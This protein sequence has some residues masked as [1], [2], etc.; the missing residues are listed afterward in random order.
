MRVY[1]FNPGPATL[2]TAVLEK[3]QRQF[4]DYHGK[5]LSVME[6]SHRSPE[7]D[8]IHN[9]AINNIRKIMSIPDNYH[10][11]FLQGGASTQFFHIPYN[12]LSK[13]TEADYI[14]TGSWSKKAI[15]EAKLFGKVNVAASSEDVDF[16]R[17]PEQSEMNFSENAEYVH[18]TSNNTIYG[19]QFHTYPDT[20]NIPL[21]ADMSSDIMS[22]RIDVSEFQLI[23]AGAQKNMGPAGVTLVILSDEMANKAKPDLPTMVNYK[24][25]IE[26]N[27]L[28]NTP[29]T[30]GI[31]MIKLVTDWII[32]IGGI[33]KVEEINNAKAEMLYNAID[34]NPDFF[35]GTT[36]KSSRSKMN[37][38]MRLPSED[39]EKEFIEGASKEGMIGLK[40]HRSV[41]G[42]RASLYNALP[43]DGVKKL[44]DFMEDFA[45]KHA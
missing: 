10:V 15:K 11:L 43:L 3:A 41:G 42:I 25:H 32:E 16:T 5:G 23:Y 1:N 13:E 21:I 12:F 39:L 40:G 31:Y 7:Y 35:K 37:I 38:T 22:K 8:E 18:I 14:I 19:T 36:E 4:V 26:K 30:F 9:Q 24:T 27:S 44:T 2:P 29:P 17:V 20:G 33:E 45:A 6:M 34:K 28:F